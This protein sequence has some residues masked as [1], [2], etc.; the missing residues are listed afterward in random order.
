MITFILGLII[1]SGLYG[2]FSS[3]DLGP[4]KN[5]VYGDEEENEESF[6]EVLDKEFMEKIKPVWE[7]SPDKYHGI[8]LEEYYK[9][10]F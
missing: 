10:R 9:A 7:H 6:D 2:L 8:S 4:E 3:N 1:A 5:L